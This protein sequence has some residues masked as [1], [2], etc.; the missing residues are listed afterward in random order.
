M[1]W[2]VGAGTVDFGVL[3]GDIRLSYDNGERSWEELRFGIRKIHE[4]TPSVWVEFAGSVELGFRMVR[5]FQSLSRTEY[6]RTGTP[7][8]PDGLIEQFVTREEARFPG[9]PERLRQNG[10]ELLV[11]GVRQQST[12]LNGRPIFRVA[13]GATVRFPRPA[14]SGV[15]VALLDFNNFGSIGSGADVI[16]FRRHLDDAISDGKQGLLGFSPATNPSFRNALPL[17][18]Y[19]TALGLGTVTE[20]NPV[21]GIS[22]QMFVAIVTPAGTF[23]GSNEGAELAI[24]SGTRTAVPPLPA[25][26]DSLE[27]WRRLSER[28]PPA[29]PSV[30]VC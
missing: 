25:I 19:L 23:L 27:G 2:V 3:A 30:A 7:P 16:E 10:Y 18:G 17:D 21:L 26:A 13:M 6:Q 1:T 11:V 28:F 29:A 5:R 20:C 4:V 24:E 14:E 22:S 15:N 9:L 8:E 12:E